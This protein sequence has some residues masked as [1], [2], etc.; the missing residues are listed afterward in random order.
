[1]FARLI[2]VRDP[3]GSDFDNKLLWVSV[4]SFVSIPKVNTS[5]ERKSHREK[6]AWVCCEPGCGK[7]GETRK[8]E[9][10]SHNRKHDS[11]KA[12]R[13]RFSQLEIGS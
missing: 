3:T 1:M 6:C 11:D 5:Y 10:D 8:R 4:A 12:K 9:I 13:L 2:V 7:T